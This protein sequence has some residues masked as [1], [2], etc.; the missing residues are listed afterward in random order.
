MRKWAGDLQGALAAVD[1]ALDLDDELPQAH[2]NRGEILYHLGRR[3]EAKR[4][5]QRAVTLSPHVPDAHYWLGRAY[6]DEGNVPRA[7]EELVEALNRQ[8]RTDKLSNVT[9]AMV[10]EQ[11]A[12][13]RPPAVSQ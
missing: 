9:R 3:M 2:A 1:A 6:L 13:T 7:R 12:R 11:L 4:H 5:L 10:L 8:I